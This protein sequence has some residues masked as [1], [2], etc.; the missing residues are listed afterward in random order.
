MAAYGQCRRVTRC[1]WAHSMNDFCWYSVTQLLRNFALAL[2]MRTQLPFLVTPIANTAG[3]LL[4]GQVSMRTAIYN[5]LRD[6]VLRAAASSDHH[7][8]AELL[9]TYSLPANSTAGGVAGATR[10]TGVA[11]YVLHSFSRLIASQPQT[12]PR[13]AFN[14]IQ[15]GI[16][17]CRM[18]CNCSRALK[19][20]SGVSCSAHNCS[21]CA[22]VSDT[23]FSRRFHTHSSCASCLPVR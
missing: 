6:T 1:M 17:F 10:A 23:P 13:C 22:G 3:H 19:S 16:H 12:A 4:R 7:I 18:M 8:C 15:K 9:S 21:S 5:A 20:S 2:R 11:T 14:P